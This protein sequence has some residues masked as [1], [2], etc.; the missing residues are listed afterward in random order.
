M[1][2]HRVPDFDLPTSRRYRVSTCRGSVLLLDR[3]L[4][5]L[6]VVGADGGEPCLQLNQEAELLLLQLLLDKYPQGA[7]SESVLLMYRG[8]NL[9]DCRAD[10]EVD[11][12][13]VSDR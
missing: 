5:G 6:D 13:D 12:G 10:K 4:Y 2:D 11:R 8:A 1:R 9:E 7:R 3:G